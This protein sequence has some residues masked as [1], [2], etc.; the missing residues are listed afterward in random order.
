MKLKTKK[1]TVHIVE[2]DDFDK[3]V[4]NIYGGNYEF[5]ADHEAQNYSCYKFEAPNMNMPWEK[6]DANI[7]KGIYKG[8]THR[9]FRC[10]YEDGHIEKG[11]YIIK[12]FW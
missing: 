6:D 10:L 5:V 3:F 11:T 4:N 12:V 9:L 8:D 1:Q 2:S 7:R